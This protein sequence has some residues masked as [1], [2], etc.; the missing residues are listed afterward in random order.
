MRYI[1]HRS[2]ELYVCVQ[3]DTVLLMGRHR[4]EIK[5]TIQY[6]Q[7]SRVTS[8]IK[9]TMYAGIF[10]IIRL[11]KVIR[12]EAVLISFWKFLPKHSWAFDANF[13]G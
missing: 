7:C 4:A 2:L 12:V 8:F 11:M 13:T 6:M 9:C 3:C 5:R 10:G 1:I